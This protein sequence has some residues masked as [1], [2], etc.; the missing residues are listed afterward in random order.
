MIFSI[1]VK[2]RWWRQAF[3]KQD[4]PFEITTII[5]NLQVNQ[6]SAY[7]FLYQI[8]SKTGNHVNVGRLI[9][10]DAELHDGDAHEDSV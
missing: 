8:W 1:E 7:P 10:L 9:S 3:Y 2:D 5:K 4:W 6:I